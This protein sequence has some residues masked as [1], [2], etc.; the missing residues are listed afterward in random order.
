[1]NGTLLHLAW[2]FG[3][4]SM[5]SVGGGSSLLPEMQRQ[6]AM[7]GWIDPEGFSETY[8]LGQIVPGPPMTMVGLLGYHAAGLAGALVVLVA[9]FLPPSL[10]V[11]V[12]HRLWARM[13]NWRWRPAIQAGVAPISVGLLLAGAVAIG[14]GAVKDW[15]GYSLVFVSAAISL[16][17]DVNPAFL[18]LGCGM[19]KLILG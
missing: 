13:S 7:N 9:F 8:S 1:L 12:V 6:C 5:L 4:L 3:W 18:V 17:K 11:F 14:Q 2:T 10:L 15:S 19:L 16:W